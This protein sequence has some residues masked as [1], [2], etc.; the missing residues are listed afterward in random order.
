MKSPVISASSPALWIFVLGFLVCTSATSVIDDTRT[1]APATEP[2]EPKYAERFKQMIANLLDGASNDFKRKLLS[3]ELSTVCSLGLLKFIRGIKNLEPW[4]MRMFD[5]SGKYPNGALQTTRTD[6]GAFDECVET[7][8][9]DEYG[10]EKVRGQY[11]NL[12]LYAGNKTDLDDYIT[13][14]MQMTHPRVSCLFHSS[15]PYTHNKQFYP[16]HGACITIEKAVC[17]AN[18]CNVGSYT[19]A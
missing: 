16:V 19:N 7:V 10:N 13:R 9:H 6:L 4:A 8:V 5:A 15:M 3:A 18:G 2:P 17:I 14:A 1:E 12:Q 11:C